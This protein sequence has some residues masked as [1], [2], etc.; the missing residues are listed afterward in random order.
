MGPKPAAGAGTKPCP[1]ALG[2]CLEKAF[3]RAG[4]CGPLSVPSHSRGWQN[5][6]RVQGVT[7]HVQQARAQSPCLKKVALT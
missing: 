4:Q 7:K 1:G 3:Y 2:A 6:A 5:Q